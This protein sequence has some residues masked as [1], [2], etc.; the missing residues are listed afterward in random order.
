MV[1]LKNALEVGKPLF[2][3]NERLQSDSWWSS[4]ASREMNRRRSSGGGGAARD[5]ELERCRH[6]GT[7]FLGAIV[8]AVGY[9]STKSAHQ[10][11]TGDEGAH[12]KRVE[13]KNGQPWVFIGLR[14]RRGEAIL[15]S[16]KAGFSDAD[17]SF[18]AMDPSFAAADP[19]AGFTII[20]P[21][22]RQSKLHRS[23]PK[24]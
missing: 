18:A 11:R 20:L 9:K 8:V 24:S 10:T 21:P 22:Q 13:G 4:S 1:K 23:E 19:R 5:M 3:T 15:C 16:G 17:P 12:K 6:A 2:G 14:I 7:V